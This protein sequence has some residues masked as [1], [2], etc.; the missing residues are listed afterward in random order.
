MRVRWLDTYSY[1]YDGRM[2]MYL[3]GLVYTFM[4]LTRDAMILI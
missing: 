3:L 1:E 4:S 2:E